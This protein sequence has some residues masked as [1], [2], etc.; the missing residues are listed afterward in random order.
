MAKLIPVF[1]LGVF[2][3]LV[4]ASFSSRMKESALTEA[5]RLDS[6][7]QATIVQQYWM[8]FF[9]NGDNMKQDPASAALIDEGHVMHIRNLTREGKM[10]L[11]GAFAEYDQIRSMYVLRA[12]DSLEAVRLVMSDTAV[13]T[14]RL[15]FEL[16]PWWTA[17][18]CVFR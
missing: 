5:S 4:I 10:M 16:K 9:K 11:A 12:A 2:L 15:D 14:G 8:V 13:A 7:A 1:L 18:N 3:T 17:R 6:V